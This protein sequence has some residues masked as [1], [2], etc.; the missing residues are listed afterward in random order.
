MVLNGLRSHIREKLE[1]YDFLTINQVLQKALAQESRSKDA[2]SK[3]DRPNIHVLNNDSSDDKNGEVYAAEFVWPS[4]AKSYSCASLKPI[5]KN[6]QEDI[7][8][9]FD[10]SKCDKI[11]DEL[12]KNG[13]IKFA[14]TIPPLDELKRRAFCKFHNSFLHAT[15]DCN[16][17]RRHIQLAINEG[18]LTVHEM[19]IDKN[20]FPSTFSVNTIKM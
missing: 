11:F 18:Q 16:M 1:G 17:F 20:P 6:R 5:H 9:I 15:N 7:K 8:F 12:H 2:R 19:Q 10:V 4:K 13:Y 3:S 14:Y